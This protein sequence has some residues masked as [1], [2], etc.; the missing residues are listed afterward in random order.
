[1]SSNVSK[2]KAVPVLQLV[3][4]VVDSVVFGVL[5][6]RNHLVERK[7]VQNYTQVFNSSEVDLKWLSSIDTIGLKTL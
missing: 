5:V 2:T 3:N 7:K 1:M 6:L 4:A